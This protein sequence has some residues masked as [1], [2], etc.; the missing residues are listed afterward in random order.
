MSNVV[1]TTTDLIFLFSFATYVPQLLSLAKQPTLPTTAEPGNK[2][3]GFDPRICRVLLICHVSRLLSA[4]LGQPL[5][6]NIIYQSIGMLV[7]QTLTVYYS[8][9]NKSHPIQEYKKEL[10]TI[11]LSRTH[12][13]LTIFTTTI[14]TLTVITDIVLIEDIVYLKDMW[15][16][17][18]PLQLLPSSLLT[19]R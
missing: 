4:F 2:S 13:T 17:F 3:S 6:Q 5:N 10:S 12:R 15:Y 1:S 18:H 16:G 7:V 19:F 9:T 8:S 14:L 11:I